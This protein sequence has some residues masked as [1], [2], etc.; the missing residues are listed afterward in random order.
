MPWSTAT[1]RRRAVV[2]KHDQSKNLD[3]IGKIQDEQGFWA[4]LPPDGIVVDSWDVVMGLGRVVTLR[5]PPVRPR[6]VNRSIELSAWKAFRTEIY[7]TYDFKEAAKR[8][9]SG[10][11]RSDRLT[12]RRSGGC[13]RDRARDRA[14]SPDARSRSAPPPAGAA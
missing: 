2:L 11:S 10:R 7:A 9:G 8:S 5:V 12:G 3:D 14:G 4:K 1:R 13:G 6:E